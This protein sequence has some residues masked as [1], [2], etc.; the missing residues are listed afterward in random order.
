MMPNKISVISGGFDPIHSGHL[1]YIREAASLGDKL[2]ILLNSDSWLRLKKGQEFMSFSERKVI[3]ESLKG[4][5]EVFDFQDDD[6]G[7]CKKG[8]EKIKDMYPDDEIIF[9]N[10]GDRVEGNIPELSV[11]N[12]KFKFNVGGCDKKNS[13]SEILNN[14]KYST[15]NRVWGKFYNLL[16][17][18]HIKV[19]E[20]VI[21]PHKGMSFQR[22]FHRH[23]FW[24]ISHGKCIINL[25]KENPKKIF[26]KTMSKFDHFILPIESWH[27][28]TNPFDQPCRII[29]IQFGAKVEE[30][31]IERLFY[32]EEN[33]I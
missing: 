26:S 28:I 7:S 17:N 6:L 22:H 16:V 10:G 8:L 30:Q 9:C 32:Y 1:Q 19:K 14:W 25:A 31:D 18:K 3:L 24:L 5:D 29:E 23:E 21:H 2:F 4:V 20:L 11:K 12:I 27:Q 33:S 13:S 15:E